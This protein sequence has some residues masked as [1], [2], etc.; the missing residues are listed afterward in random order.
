MI[1]DKK[2]IDAKNV[3]RARIERDYMYH[4]PKG[5]QA[6]RYVRL[7]ACA[8][9]L[10]L[11]IVDLTPVSRE[12]STALTHLDAVVYNANAAIARNE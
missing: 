6:E 3:L 4:A 7:R 5:D 9:Q 2:E 11:M 10:A 1:S 12:Q 8:K